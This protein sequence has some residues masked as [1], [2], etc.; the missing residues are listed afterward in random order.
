[1]KKHGLGLFAAFA[2]AM[3]ATSA[4]CAAEAA[5][6][7]TSASTSMFADLFIL[8]LSFSFMLWLPG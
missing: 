1:M 4:F 5:Q 2:A 7:V 3:L 6:A 8:F